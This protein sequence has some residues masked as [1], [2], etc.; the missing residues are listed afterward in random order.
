MQWKATCS[1]GTIKGISKLQRCLG[2]G[3]QMDAGTANLLHSQQ[4]LCTAAARDTKLNGRVC[5]P[6]NCSVK[7]SQHKSA[8]SSHKP[9]SSSHRGQL[10]TQ[11]PSLTS[12]PCVSVGRSGPTIQLMYHLPYMSP[13]VIGSKLKMRWLSHH[14]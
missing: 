3:R 14:H 4:S 7:G 6:R 2:W 5:L 12:G 8:F 1:P 10:N 9:S 13:G 11:A